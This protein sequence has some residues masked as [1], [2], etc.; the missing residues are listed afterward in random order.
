MSNYT[1]V[2]HFMEV[3]GQE[4]KKK[5]EF[6]SDEVVDLRYNLIAEELFELGEAIDEK[7]LV[8]VADALTDILYVT[9]G[10]AAAFGIDIDACFKEVHR[11]N[12]TKLDENGKPVY[13]EDGKIIKPSTYTPPNLEFI[14]N[15]ETK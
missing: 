7:D 8:A 4:V 2:V 6:P 14:I 5:P 1:D 12:M 3:F 9:Y 13:R 15:E 11:S 10:A